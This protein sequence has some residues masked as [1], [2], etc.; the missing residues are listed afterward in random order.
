[1]FRQHL[2]ALLSETPFSAATIDT[3]ERLRNHRRILQQKRMI[4]E[5]FTE[6][7][8][9]MMTLDERFFGNVTGLR[10][11][12]GAGVYPMRE[13]YVD[14]LATDI[15]LNPWMDRMLDASAMDLDDCSVRAFYGQNCFHH[16]PRVESFFEEVMRVVVPG[17]GVI[18]IEPYYGPLAQML[19]PRL[20]TTEGF[21]KGAVSWD[22]VTQ[23]PM[24]G[25]NQA[26][27]YIVFVRDRHRFMQR[28]PRLHIC[29]TAPLPN[30]LRYLLSG[31]LNFKQLTPDAL[32]GVVKRCEQLLTPVQTYLALHH[33]IVLQ[34]QP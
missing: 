34:R 32:V 31:G 30:Y 12:L 8:H 15:V 24:S 17:G 4:R 25:A 29:H 3:A 13:T 27:S 10:V 14:V 22:T 9:A 18:L 23:G 21:D 26:R 5:V 19:F 11:E 33:V 7:H 2:C 1:M 6:F 20:F 16:F 28:F